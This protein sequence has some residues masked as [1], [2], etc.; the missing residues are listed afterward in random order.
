MPRRT[1][2]WTIPLALAL[3]LGATACSSSDADS[4]VSCEGTTCA[5][6]L[7]GVGAEADVLGIPVVLENVADGSA[8]VSVA[9]QTLSLALDQTLEAGGASVRLVSTTEE[10]V[11]LQISV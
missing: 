10:E 9:G 5:I 6:T 2:L 7:R 1:R 3:S 8:E 4:T 11:E